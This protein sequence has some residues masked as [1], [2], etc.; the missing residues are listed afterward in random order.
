MTLVCAFDPGGTTG[1]A[2][3]DIDFGNN[4]PT[5]HVID[6]KEIKDFD[7][8][9]TFFVKHVIWAPDTPAAVLVERFNLF[10]HKA[11]A[12]IGSDFPSAQ[13]IGVIRYT[14]HT[15]KMDKILRFQTPEQKSIITNEMLRN[16][17]DV[18]SL[19]SSEHIRDALRHIIFWGL[20]MRY[21]KH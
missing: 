13:W 12:Q 17:L 15:H 9:N 2:V 11:Q 3:V 10:P 21:G 5:Y 7:D 19:P 4:V 18:V 8:Y 1:F 6:M 20:E 16:R 14:L